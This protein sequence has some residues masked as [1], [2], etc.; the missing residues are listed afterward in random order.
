MPNSEEQKKQ[1]AYISEFASSFAMDEYNSKTLLIRI[2]DHTGST[3]TPHSKAVIKQLYTEWFKGHYA[4]DEY[5]TQFL[6]NKCME[7]F[8]DTN[9][10]TSHNIPTTTDIDSKVKNAFDYAVN[11]YNTHDRSLYNQQFCID[12]M[13][14]ITGFDMATCYKIVTPILQFHFMN[15]TI[16][17]GN[18][19]IQQQLN[20]VTENIRNHLLTVQPTMQPDTVQAVPNMPQVPQ[21]PASESIN[22]RHG[23]KVV[24]TSQVGVDQE[25]TSLAV[26][27]A[28]SDAKAFPNYNNS[29]NSL[30]DTRAINLASSGV[31]DSDLSKFCAVINSYTFNL[32]A[33]YLNNNA[34]G[35]NGIAELIPAIKGSKYTK[36]RQF[37][38]GQSVYPPRIVA[39]DLRFLN[40]KYD[41]SNPKFITQNVVFLNLCNNNIGD[42]GAKTIADALTSGELQSTKEIDLHGN[43]ITRTGEGYFTKALKSD[44]VQDIIVLTQ[45]LNNNSKLIFGSKEERKVELKKFIQ[46]SKAKGID[47]DHI[48]VD[49]TFLGKIKNTINQGAVAKLAVTGFAKCHWSLEDVATDYAQDKIMAKIP[50]KLATV[51]KT[52]GKTLDVKS[53]V[54]CYIEA[55]DQAWSSEVGL[56]AVH[57]ELCVMGEQEFCGE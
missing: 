31:K 11:F 26:N 25:G 4:M 10:Q 56:S 48:V 18:E 23:G 3:P 8:G 51:F 9:N 22:S 15:E 53:M 37:E 27:K 30:G 43:S 42:R 47:S 6:S 19:V 38:N 55:T 34:I 7:I 28:I 17:I 57:H 21:V 2:K 13:V 33:L 29:Y 35:N 20:M 32:E 39:E 24:G 44:T 12:E 46:L 50:G 5:N 36:Y 1:N 41:P 45:R 40:Y 49:T 54:S 16:N 14:R 52:I